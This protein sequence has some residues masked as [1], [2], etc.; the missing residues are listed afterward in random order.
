MNNKK[1]NNEVFESEFIIKD[2]LF[3]KVELEMNDEFV[4]VD[5]ELDEYETNFVLNHKDWYIDKK[6]NVR[7]FG[8]L[9]NKELL[10]IKKWDI[11]P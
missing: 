9:D 7:H 10:P 4:F 3:G 5:I 1:I 2:I 6:I 11:A 8:K